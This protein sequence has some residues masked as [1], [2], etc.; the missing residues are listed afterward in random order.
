MDLLV[1]SALPPY[2]LK[3]LPLFLQHHHQLPQVLYVQNVMLEN[4]EFEVKLVFRLFPKIDP[5]SYTFIFKFFLNVY[6]FKS[7]GHYW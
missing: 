2:V 6:N 1:K 3:C 4:P 7:S 5:E